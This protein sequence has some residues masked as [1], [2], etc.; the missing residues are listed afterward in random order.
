MKV[1]LGDRAFF[2]DLI[3][4]RAQS[5]RESHNR[6]NILCLFFLRVKF[7]NK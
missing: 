4:N 2:I 7:Y 6:Q 5:M 3:N 1:D